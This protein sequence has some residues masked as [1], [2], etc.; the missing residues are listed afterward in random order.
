MAERKEQSQQ[1][2]PFQ[3]PSQ[4]LEHKDLGSNY[5]CGICQCLCID[6]QE[7]SCP[8][9]NENPTLD[10]PLYCKRCLLSH[11]KSNGNRCPITIS[12]RHLVKYNP[13]SARVKRTIAKLSV[14][15]PNGDMFSFSTLL[16][17]KNKKKGK[18]VGMFSSVPLLIFFFA[19]QYS[20]TTGF[21]PF[22]SLFVSLVPLK[23]RQNVPQRHP[24]FLFRTY[25]SNYT[26]EKE[27]FK[28][29]A[30]GKVTSICF[31][32]I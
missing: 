2:V 23:K 14:F 3:V 7:L 30:H 1:T 6:P 25:V 9:H 20:F 26:G 28:T 24:F 10:I 16:P 21:S 18:I 15:C 11:L 22:V 31:Q 4:C 12:D 8:I 13:C 27:I 29:Y 17:P 5:V 32:P 19:P